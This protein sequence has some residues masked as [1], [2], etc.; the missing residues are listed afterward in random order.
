MIMHVLSMTPEQ[1]NMLG[2]SE[3]ASIHQ[4]VC[5]SLYSSR[6]HNSFYVFSVPPHRVNHHPA[7]PLYGLPLHF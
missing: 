7:I 3:R 1:I 2:P 4:L 5:G 6:I